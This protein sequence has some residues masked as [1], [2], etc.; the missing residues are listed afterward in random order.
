MILEAER[1]IWANPETGYKEYKT[2]KYLEE[3]FEFSNGLNILTGA[4]AQGKTNAAEAIFFLCTGYSPRA[5]KDKIVI[6]NVVFDG[7]VVNFE[8]K[9]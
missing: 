4:N 7:Y 2:S 5:N 6:K 9:G 8:E 1:Y 3:E